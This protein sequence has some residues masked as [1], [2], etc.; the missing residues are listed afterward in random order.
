[1]T[2]TSPKPKRSFYAHLP[3]GHVCDCGEP[4]YKKTGG[5]WTCKR[6]EDLNNWAYHAGYNVNKF[7]SPEMAGDVLGFP[8][9]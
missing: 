7:N 2:N 6:C 5:G 4:A 3:L 1:M 9:A 8:L